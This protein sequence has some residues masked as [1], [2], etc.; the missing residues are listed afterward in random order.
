MQNNSFLFG[1]VYEAEVHLPRQ[2]CSAVCRAEGEKLEVVVVDEQAVAPMHQCPAH[3]QQMPPLVA[4]E[5]YAVVPHHRQ[6]N[7][8]T[9]Q[10]KHTTS[11]HQHERA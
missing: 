8:T 5:L 4:V 2:W 10:A 6:S 1:Y 3:D 11:K 7:N 9:T